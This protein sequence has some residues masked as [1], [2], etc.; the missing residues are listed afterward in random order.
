MLR[1]GTIA[2]LAVC[3][4]LQTAC[5]PPPPATEAGAAPTRPVRRSSTLITR[6]E[7]ATVSSR[8]ALG[9][10]RTLRPEWLHVR[11]AISPQAGVPA[12][13]V[14]LDGNRVGTRD[15]LSQIATVHI[16]EIRFLSATD[17]TQKWGTDHAGGVIEVVTR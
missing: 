13:L 2:A 5:A 4:A 10:I 16:R 15:V 14:Y 11:G 17:A 8:D 9:A 1:T 6:E 3:V 12:L 7:L